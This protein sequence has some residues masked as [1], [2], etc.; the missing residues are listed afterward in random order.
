MEYW[1]LA[2][3]NFLAKE[4]WYRKVARSIVTILDS[5]KAFIG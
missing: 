3:F 4:K 5:D 2:R 1:T